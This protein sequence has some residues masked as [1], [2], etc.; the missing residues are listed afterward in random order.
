MADRWLYGARYI[1]DI[2]VDRAKFRTT[3]MYRVNEDLRIGAEWNPRGNDLGPIANWRFQEET[4]SLPALILGTSSARI[5]TEDGRAIYVT[6]SKNVQSWLNLPVA[7]YVGANWDG[8]DHKLRPIGGFSVG[9][10]DKVTSTHFHDGVNV[11]HQLSLNLP[12]GHSFGLLLVN[13]GDEEYVGM[14]YGLRF[15]AGWDPLDL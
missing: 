7:P 15:G 1:P 5:G 8:A 6:A 14:N 4:E 10:G 2:P 11:H 3:L 12:E 13:L 9:W